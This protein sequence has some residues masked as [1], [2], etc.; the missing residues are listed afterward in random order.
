MPPRV[1]TIAPGA[2]FLA[3][4]AESFLDG[5]IIPGLGRDSGPLALAKAKIYVP[6]RRAGRALAAELA[7]RSQTPAM[8]L[9]K[10]LA[11]GA[12][13]GE[14]GEAGFDN[15][16]DPLIPR[17]VG[18]IERRMILGEL[19]LTWARSLK[20]AIVSV[21]A[22]G[23][24]RH[25]SETL[26]VATHPAD[27]WRLSG[28]LATLID[29]MIIENVEWRGLESLG[30]EFDDYWRITLKFLDI[31]IKAWPQ[32]LLERGLVDL[33]ARQQALIARAI[34]KVAGDPAP[35][36][37]IGST[38]SN[39]VTA[40]LLAA[41]AHAENGA[42]VL[43]GLDQNLDE[44]SFAAIRG[45]DEPCATHPQAFLARLIETIGVTRENVVAIGEAPPAL[46]AREKFV[47]EAFRPADSTDLWPLW[48]TRHDARE[49]AVALASVALIEAADERE[50]ALAIAVNLREAL[51]RPGRTAALV[52]PD[53]GLAE[54][55]R[56]ELLRW[57]VEI[58]DSGGSQLGASRA[59]VLARLI[60]A[61]LCGG[62]DDWAA[63]IAHPDFSL[64]LETGAERLC[65][66]FEIG[67]LRSGFQ[68]AAFAD[69]VAPARAASRDRH[70]HPRQKEIS[71][72]DWAALEVLAKKIDAAFTP[73]RALAQGRETGLRPWL[74]A[75][76]KAIA[77]IVGGDET[78][79]PG[80][81]DGEAL[82]EMFDE[83]FLSAN[84]VFT[85][86]PESYAAFFD[87][88]INER[89]LRGPSRAHPR[90][91]ILG[92]LEARLIGADRLVLSGLDETV[93][94]PRGETDSFLNRQ[95]RAT[96][97]LSSPDRR[98]GQT[99]HD[100]VQ[101]FGAAE[102]ILTRAKKR[103][104]APTTPSRFLQ[105]MEALAGANMFASLRER[106]RLWLDL[107]R[108][109]DE[110][111]SEKPL[112]RPTPCPPL[113]L[114]PDRLSVTR[115]EM[116]RRDPYAIYA[117]FIL[118]LL[119][120]PGLEY[121]PGPREIGNAMHEVLEEFVQLHP[122][123][124]LPEKAREILIAQAREKLKNF[125]DDAE[126]QSFRWPRLVRG[127]EAYLAFEA[128]RRP[129]IET[130]V[131]ETGGK[132]PLTLDD[133]SQFSLTAEA[134]RIE[135]MKDGGAVIVDYKTGKPP[136]NKE[137]RAGFAPQLTLEAAIM[138]RG[139]FR[140]V[141]ARKVETAFYLPLGGDKTKPQN[142]DD[143][144]KGPFSDL[145]AEH[146]DELVG[147]LN[148]FRNPAHGYP[149][150]PFPQ[151]AARYN[152]YDHLARTREW[153]ASGA[154]STGGEEG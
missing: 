129:D 126:F 30:G 80:G 84:E 15:P 43:P 22:D 121:D 110:A 120:L 68:A 136:S 71:D 24:V 133:G 41:I 17:A 26:L 9:P 14:N 102:V 60:L 111:P 152:D 21:D 127:L 39:V 142:L 63:L 16:L 50:E 54:R 20:R 57:N 79:F 27:A 38:G 70:A 106:G 73:L 76:K 67:V 66:L 104:G 6:T 115:I 119:P 146:F 134:D 77:L 114:R 99:A 8:L 147:L 149:A 11:L 101:A 64:G 75:H 107:A 12:L 124:P 31:A 51:E 89:I 56:A 144:K 132:L 7:R 151:F 97:G 1:F 59:G 78:L 65:A 100:F 108:K 13:D 86:R 139:A 62:A 103:G 83:L 46:A 29:E 72:S 3:T 35:V 135:L 40:R 117:E 34:E 112:A 125:A 91:K 95:F 145:V 128:K 105:R 93:W 153:S 148:H 98:I 150:R 18:E 37:A 69:C 130:I 55:V 4:F 48:R 143:P 42:V 87:A 44:K 82:A 23:A 52:T 28:E 109:V 74:D 140:G 49:V 123:G 131:V 5:K 53:R 88:L 113:E 96:L 25:A 116:L 94:P 81:E 10:I 36:I 19:I 138:E 58:D 154:D 33:A 90:V 118:E 61:A 32:I 2:P 92:L 141:A 122:S 47:S 85:F 45:G 137:V